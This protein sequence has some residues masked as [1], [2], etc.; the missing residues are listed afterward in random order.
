L[1]LDES[2]TRL[3]PDVGKSTSFRRP[4]RWAEKRNCART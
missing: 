4:G 1:A 2:L 3:Y